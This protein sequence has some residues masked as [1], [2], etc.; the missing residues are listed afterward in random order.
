MCL[1]LMFS[2]NLIQEGPGMLFLLLNYSN[3]IGLDMRPQQEGECK[4]ILYSDKSSSIFL[5]LTTTYL[6][7]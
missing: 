3:L 5:F 6:I 4:H 1:W 2:Q 7:I